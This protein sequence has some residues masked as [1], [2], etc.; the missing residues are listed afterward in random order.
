MTIGRVF[1]L[2]RRGVFG[3]VLLAAVGCD[4]A[5]G[6]SAPASDPSPVQAQIQERPGLRVGSAAPN[7][8]LRDLRGTPLTLSDYRGKVVLINFWATWC[9]PCRVEMPG[10]EVLYRE[11][12]RK[13]FEILAV[14]TDQQGVAVTRPFRDEMGLTFPIL[15]DSDFRVGVVYGARTLPMTFLVDRH[16]IIT[17]RIFGARDWQS[18]QGRELIRTLMKAP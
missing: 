9:G 10:M 4:A 12:D 1:G 11:F 13:D 5:P 15:H 8:Q 17:H 7:F 2:A 16:G 14:S 3:T 6:D 18:P